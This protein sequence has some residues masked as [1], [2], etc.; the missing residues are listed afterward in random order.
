MAEGAELELLEDGFKFTEGPAA[1]REGNLYFTDQPNN[2]IMKWSV[3]DSTVSVYMEKAGRANGL[4]FDKE[5][6]LLACADENSE[7]WKIDKD[8]N[9][10]VLVND[11]EGKRLN[12]PNDLWVDSKGGV[13][14]TDPYY[15]RDYWERTK[16]DIESERVYYLSPDRKK[17]KIVIDDFEQPNGIVGTPDGKTLYVADIGAKKTWSYNIE[18]DGSLGG[19]KLFAEMGSDGMTIDSNGNVYLTGKGVTVFNKA[20]EKIDHILINKDWTGNLIFGGEDH[21]TLFITAMD[22]VYSLKMNVK[23]VRW[24][25]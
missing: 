24:E 18:P 11:F 16:K 4:F 10:T 19:K 9:V 13:Y 6:N 12:G 8:K 21:Q 22:A 14:F 25:Q 23:G 1:D 15:Q 2:R 3:V 7:L 5:E 17:L 20:G